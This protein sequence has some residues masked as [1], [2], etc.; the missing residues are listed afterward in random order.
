MADLFDPM[1]LTDSDPPSSLPRSRYALSGLRTTGFAPVAKHRSKDV[2]LFR[3][4]DIDLIVDRDPQSAA[5]CFAAE[6]GPSACGQA[7]RVEDSHQAQ[8]RALAHR[9]RPLAMPV[10]PMKWRLPG[11][12]GRRHR[13]TTDGRY[14]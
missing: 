5:A 8:A 3:Q 11:D 10:G 13:A 6:H 9:A 4:G 7:F 2:V 1:D 14:P 12:R